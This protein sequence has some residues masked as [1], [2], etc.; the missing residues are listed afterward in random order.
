[1]TD[2]PLEAPSGIRMTNVPLEAP[3]GILGTFA[4]WGV[5]NV[6]RSP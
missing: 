1:M 4:A 3:S 2:V 5:T 6:P